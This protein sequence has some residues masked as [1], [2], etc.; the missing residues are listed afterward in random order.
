MRQF[1]ARHKYWARKARFPWA[2]ARHSVKE[3]AALGLALASAR[4]QAQDL[5]LEE[6]CL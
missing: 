1:P 2:V 3:A 4:E 5:Q 6:R